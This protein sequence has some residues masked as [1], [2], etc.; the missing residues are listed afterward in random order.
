M[1][2]GAAVIG[3]PVFLFVSCGWRIHGTDNFGMEQ[4]ARQLTHG[5]RGSLP[6]KCSFKCWISNES[7][8]LAIRSVQR[9]QQVPAQRS[10]SEP[11]PTHGGRRCTSSKCRDQFAE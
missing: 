9:M 10:V 8:A 2:V 3:E 4:S 1:D 6:P 5:L 7:G 11:E